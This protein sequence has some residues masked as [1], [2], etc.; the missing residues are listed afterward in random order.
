MLTFSGVANAVTLYTAPAAQ[1]FPADQVLCCSILNTS[2]ATRAVEIEVRG[3]GSDFVGGGSGPIGPKQSTEV[4]VF[5]IGNGAY[6]KFEIPGS[7]RSYRAAAL[8]YDPVQEVY[9]VAVPVE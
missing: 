5:P 2:S 6:C 8:Y 7:S 4:C 1:R 9:T 3:Y